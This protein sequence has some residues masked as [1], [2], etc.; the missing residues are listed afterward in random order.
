[1]IKKNRFCS[2]HAIRMRGS[3]VIRATFHGEPR[4]DAS[5]GIELGHYVGRDAAEAA[6]RAAYLAIAGV[7]SRYTDDGISVQVEPLD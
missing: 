3:F 1:M 6:M 4:R 7:L 2:V 5:G